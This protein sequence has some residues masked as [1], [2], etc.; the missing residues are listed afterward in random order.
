M[1]RLTALV[2]LVFIT[3]R[4]FAQESVVYPPTP[5][6]PGYTARLNVVYCKV[7][8]YECKM[9][10]YLAPKGGKPAPVVINIHGGGWTNGVKESQNGFGLFFKL[11][12]SVANIEYRMLPVAPAPAA[13]E[14]ARCALIYLISNAKELNLDANRI[15]LMG[16]SAGAHLALMA[17]LVGTN[18]IFDSDCPHQ[19]MVRPA[20]I[21]DL[22]GPTDLVAMA[23]MFN[24]YN[25]VTNWLGPH[26]GDLNFIRFISPI[27]F[28]SK[29]SP[30]VLILHG[31]ND[32]L[33]PYQQSVDLE[34]KLRAAGVKTK[35][36]TVQGG[37]HGGFAEAKNLEFNAL[38][39]SFLTE[40]G[41]YN[42]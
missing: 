2:T 23:P 1:K 11:G 15:V 3:T 27:N 25:A 8:N 16:S 18:T 31:T 30:P 40:L 37:G 29:Y 22:Y 7:F 24:G 20:A 13:I 35:M 42:P 10:L 39:E 19:H 41:L 6:P 9:D 32:P 28:V 34:V 38:V 26:K 4:L 12:Y 21:I 14:D 5:Y 33:V 17:G 36:M